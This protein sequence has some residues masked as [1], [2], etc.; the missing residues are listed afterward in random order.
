MKAQITE[1]NRLLSHQADLM[2]RLGPSGI[3]SLDLCN[4]RN[5]SHLSNGSHVST[6]KMI[7]SNSFNCYYPYTIKHS[8][9]LYSFFCFASEIIGNGDPSSDRLCFL[10]YPIFLWTCHSDD[11]SF[12]PSFIFLVYQNSARRTQ[13]PENMQL[14]LSAAL[15][16]VYSATGPSMHS[17]LQTALDLSS[18]SRN[19]DVTGNMLLA[20]SSNGGTVRA[21]P[22]PGYADSLPYGFVAHNNLIEHRALLGDAAVSSFGGVEPNSQPLNVTL[23]DPDASSF[24]YIEHISQP[25]APPDLVSDFSNGNGELSL[26]PPFPPTS[27]TCL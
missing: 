7:L 23:L 21:F 12:I 6:C 2:S 22:E 8:Y 24:G 17:S 9:D 19:L 18:H 27:Q 14:P 10:A 4:G 25:F 13:N 11:V 3:A 16:N 20:Q 15:P 5:G 26:S 1:F